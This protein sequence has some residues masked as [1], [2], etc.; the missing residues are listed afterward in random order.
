MFS[1]RGLTGTLPPEW[2]NM[3][4][5][6]LFDLR[7]NSITGTLPPEWASLF[8]RGSNGFINLASNFLTGTV[9]KEWANIFG[10]IVL[11]SNFLYGEIEAFLKEGST[12]LSF[13]IADNKLNGTLPPVIT[14]THLQSLD[15]SFN[16]FTGRIPC[17]EARNLT[18]LWLRGN[19]GLTEIP[20]N[21]RLGVSAP[22]LKVLSVQGT[23]V[24]SL[25]MNIT[26]LYPTLEQLIVQNLSLA[27]AAPDFS[28]W[29]DQIRVLDLSGNLWTNDSFSFKVGPVIN[30]LDITS[31]G[32]VPFLNQDM[33]PSGIQHC[34]TYVTPFKVINTTSESTTLNGVT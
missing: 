21:C 31:P 15:I 17:I 5:A 19:E 28:A 26:R 18:D 2:A 14:S 4:N 30:L 8:S 6:V 16:Q 27:Q 25:P 29:R 12:V 9:P 3:S 32:K 10:S 13:A 11:S 33:C 22:Y 24:R 1:N 7:A 23:S 20:T 34:V